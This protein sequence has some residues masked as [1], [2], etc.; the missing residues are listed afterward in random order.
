[1]S[2]M[3]VSRQSRMEIGAGTANRVS[4]VP[5]PGET[6]KVQYIIVMPDATS[7][8]NGTNYLSLRPY[9]GDGTGTPLS[10]ARDTSATSL[11]RG[12]AVKIGPSTH[13]TTPD[14]NFTATGS[15]LE[16]TVANP[17]TIQVTHAASGVAGSLTITAY[18]ER[19]RASV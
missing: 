7:A 15:D 9:K 13:P 1:M 3:N 18:F 2:S 8:T 12:T 19:L 17:L 10:A 4:F 6:W 11:T 5:D 14:I 16:V